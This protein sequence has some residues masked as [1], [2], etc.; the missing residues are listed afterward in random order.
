[1]WRWAK[2]LLAVLLSV[3][4][5]W[6]AGE[7][8]AAA[9]TAPA[10]VVGLA[11]RVA[12]LQSAF[13][14]GER[15]RVEAAVRE[16]DLLRRNF[17]TLDVRPLVDAMALWAREQGEQG[18]PLLGLKVLDE[19][20]RWAPRHPEVLSS[21]VI[22]LRQDGLKGYIRSL[23]DVLEL[24]RLRLSHPIHRW[25][26]ILQHVGWFRFMATVLL[27]GWA[28]AL[29]LRYRRVFRDVW[30]DP[31]RRKGIHG[32]VAA[33]VGALILAL[34]V[35]LRLDPSVSAMLWLWLL[36]PF[37]MPSEARLTVLILLLQL[38]HPALA[39]MDPKATEVPLPSLVA[40]QTQPQVRS[41][42]DVMGKS[43][44]PQDRGFL[45]GW[46]QLQGQAWVEAEST[47][48]GLVGNHP[49]QPEVLNN[50]GVA[51]FQQGKIEEAQRSFDQAFAQAPKSPEILLNQSVIAFL[52]LDSSLGLN[53]QEEAK[54][55]APEGYDRIMSANQSRTEQ[56]TFALPLPETPA[57]NQ[58]LA[59][60]QGIPTA[61]EKSPLQGGAF[62]FNL[63]LPLGV[64]AAFLLRIR[65]S[66]KVAHPAQCIRCGDAFHTTDSP[67][68]G[69]CSKCHHLFVLKD[70]L[71]SESRKRK[72]DEVAV[73]QN[74]QR[75]I[76]RALMVL[77]PGADLCF[78]G[79]AQEGF[80][81]LLFLC[82]ALGMVF[83]TGR[84][85][86]YPGDILP[87]PAS[88]WLPVGLGLLAIL[89]LRSWLKLIPRRS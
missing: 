7:P 59:S 22:L 62:L 20:E 38:S 14:S 54:V 46:Y 40:L 1:M 76:H 42:L 43:L 68:P 69:I 79:E 50:L 82:F 56:R 5:G 67:D 8:P 52:Q 55:L 72:V 58:A 3:G 32:L 21:R 48:Q 83:A 85:V 47:F 77:L 78:L 75:W 9:S 26:W 70:G 61:G 57:R 84:S 28:L 2:G 24:T 44:S 41:A 10:P 11:H 74:Q 27:W 80:V 73:F 87:D 71:H 34:P 18:Q 63:V 51:K 13:K 17:G 19:V 12:H 39:L 30:E 36:A 4:V 53:K 33:L 49:D 37:L 65:H 88:T 86:R 60:A 31:L 23:P 25:L 89:F 6:G 64:I 35:L 16:V 45:E 15:E 29:G 81:E 66:I